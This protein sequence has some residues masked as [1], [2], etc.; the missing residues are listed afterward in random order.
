MRSKP[1]FKSVKG[2]AVMLGGDVFM[3]SL[4]GNRNFARILP[5][6]AEARHHY[7]DL[8]PIAVSITPLKPPKKKKK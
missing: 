2:W 6:R 4:D 1:P 8:P 7:P 5:T 3:H